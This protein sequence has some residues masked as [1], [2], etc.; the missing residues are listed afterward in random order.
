MDSFLVLVILI[1]LCLSPSINVQ[2]KSKFYDK[3]D[4]AKLQS[5]FYSLTTNHGGDDQ[6][7]T[8]NIIYVVKSVDVQ[9]DIV[10]NLMG[11]IWAPENHYKDAHIRL[12]SPNNRIILDEYTSG[13]ISIEILESDPVGMYKIY[14]DMQT[15]EEGLGCCRE[16]VYE[17]QYSG[18]TIPPYVMAHGDDFIFIP[19]YGY[20][21]MKNTEDILDLSFYGK[22]GIDYT[23]QHNPWGENN[24]VESITL[25]N[26]SGSSNSISE[27]NPQFSYGPLFG[28]P[29][30][31]SET[32]IH[33]L[34]VDFT[35]SSYQDYR[36]MGFKL[37]IDTEDNFIDQNHFLPLFS[38]ISNILDSDGD[39]I[40]DHEEIT[41]NYLDS[42][43]DDDG[44]DDFVELVF[45]S[46]PINSLDTPFKFE[47]GQTE[48]SDNIWILEFTIDFVREIPRNIKTIN[49]QIVLPPEMERISYRNN[50]IQSIE[51]IDLIDNKLSDSRL[52]GVDDLFIN[53]AP[54]LYVTA[55]IDYDGFE[56]VLP[57]IDPQFTLDLDILGSS[58]I[59]LFFDLPGFDQNYPAIDVATPPF[60]SELDFPIENITFPILLMTFILILI[61]IARRL[62][63]NKLKI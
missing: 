28:F 17:I 19:N 49:Y 22:Q 54:Y 8:D 56:I 42:D 25:T 6:E 35:D 13:H 15:P 10:I 59:G 58:P 48:N 51:P 53:F 4:T 50:E 27:A 32:G 40:Y 31:L 55:S 36:S 52:V 39:L 43:T 63:S 3:N 24:L 18:L 60:T 16:I 5:T 62:I 61:I 23:L 37:M 29:F 14:I 9:G 44:I 30:S 38:D 21:I 2:G 34:S 11:N 57:L 33:T 47:V 45:N 20:T 12:F 1:F 7:I 46:N 41:T 26:P